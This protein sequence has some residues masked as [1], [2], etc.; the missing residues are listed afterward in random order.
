M[1]KEVSLK[2]LTAAKIIWSAAYVLYPL[3]YWLIIK[4]TSPKPENIL[5]ALVYALATSVVAL[6]LMYMFCSLGYLSGISLLLLLRF[7]IK[8]YPLGKLQITAIV[9]GSIGV[10]GLLV[11]IVFTHSQWAMPSFILSGIVT[12]PTIIITY[13]YSYKIKK[14]HII[15]P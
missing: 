14:K 8:G 9:L 1:K 3:I 13:I 4:Y 5:V 7:K 12:Y 15:T 2:I 10:I 11:W 6:F